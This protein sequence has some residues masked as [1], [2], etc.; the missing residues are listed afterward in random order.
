MQK[1]YLS[2]IIAQQRNYPS[3]FSI[4]IQMEKG[5]KLDTRFS[6]GI[7]SL[8][9]KTTTQKDQGHYHSKILC[10]ITATINIKGMYHSRCTDAVIN[11]F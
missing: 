3:L 11:L 7:L 4:T 5:N 6:L 10:F 1:C 8:M 9:V 2:S